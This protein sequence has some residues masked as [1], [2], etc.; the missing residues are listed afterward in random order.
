M[1]DLFDDT[2]PYKLSRTSDPQ[3][4]KDAAQDVSS[5][6]MLKL[7]YD[8]VVKFGSNGI[9]TKEIRA[10]YPDLPYSSIT[11]RP[12]Q[13]EEDGLVYYEG[14]KRDR[15]RVMRAK[16]YDKGFRVCGKCKCVL[17]SCYEMKCQSPKCKK[18]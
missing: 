11:A 16:T 7:V 5:G 8:E 18:D 6:K 13:L 2:P 1:D 14:D 3:T 9:T 12:A 17:L 10:I 4:S 15:C